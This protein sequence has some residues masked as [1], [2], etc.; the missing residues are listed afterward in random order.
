MRDL[1]REVNELV[2]DIEIGNKGQCAV[3]Y[4]WIGFYDDGSVETDFEIEKFGDATCPERLSYHDGSTKQVWRELSS[5]AS[6]SFDHDEIVK[7]VELREF[8]I[9]ENYDKITIASLGR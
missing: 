4:L 8:N 6:G 3:G 5:L 9:D 1:I 7:E 2:E